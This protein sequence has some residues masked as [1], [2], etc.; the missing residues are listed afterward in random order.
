M[1]YFGA[2][3][4]YIFSILSLFCLQTSIAQE[5]SLPIDQLKLV[6]ELDL[7]P[8]ESSLNAKVSI[9]CMLLTSTDSIWLDGV[10]LSYSSFLALFLLLVLTEIYFV[11]AKNIFSLIHH[12]SRVHK[13]HNN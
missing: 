6:L 4:K 12:D 9:D 2:M 7:N 10:Q 1:P 8:T 3:K 11:G 13:L 5:K